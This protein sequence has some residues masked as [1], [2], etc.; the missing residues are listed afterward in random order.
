MHRNRFPR[1]NALRK[2]IFPPHGVTK[3][4]FQEQT[5][6][7]TIFAAIFATE[8]VS[9]GQ[10]ARENPFPYHILRQKPFSRHNRFRENH[11][12][13]AI[14]GENRFPRSEFFREN[15][16]PLI[17][18]TKTV[19]QERTPRRKPFLPNFCDETVFQDQTLVEKPFTFKFRD[20]KPFSKNNVRKQYPLS[21]SLQ[22]PFSEHFWKNLHFT[23]CDGNRFQ[24]RSAQE[25]HFPL[26]LLL[27]KP[28]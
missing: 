3:R 20:K 22:K 8:T 2:T 27:Q 1:T 26:T 24:R 14:C 13:V 15:N 18:V 17:F 10:T 25:N 7:K 4:A 9:Q 11:S 19:F 6:E 5:L 28:F 12:S 23:F 16:S 21:I